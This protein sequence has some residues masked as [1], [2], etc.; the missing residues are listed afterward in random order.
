MLVLTAVLL[1]I[2][3]DVQAGRS[4]RLLDDAPLVAQADLPLPPTSMAQLQT[5]LSALTRMRP[6]MG[7][8]VT[9]VVF[10]IIGALNG[11]LLLGMSALI[12]GAIIL[13][14]PIALVGM[15]TALVGI[16]ML[17]LGAWLT[18]DRI[19]ERVRIEKTRHE[20]QRQLRELQR[21]PRYAELRMPT[22]TLASF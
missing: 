15:V 9:L 13:T 19:D 12:D 14:S 4:A 22:V 17:V 21:Q 16:P 2:S 18:W 10:G 3:G 5:D 1:T 8:P 7:G 20:L 11:G 6:S